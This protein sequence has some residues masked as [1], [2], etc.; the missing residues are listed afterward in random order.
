MLKELK[1]DHEITYLTLDDGTDAQ[2][3]E[4]AKEYCHDLICVPHHPRQK[5]TLGFYAEL[6]LNLFSSLPYAIAKY[7]SPEMRARI[8]ELASDKVY[9]VVVC[10]FLAPAANVPRDLDVHPRTLSPTCDIFRVCWVFVTE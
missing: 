4:S 10:D 3:R 7:H 5:F 9:D 1:H 6:A 2:A 8:S